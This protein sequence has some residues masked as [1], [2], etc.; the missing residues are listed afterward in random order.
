M[1]YFRYFHVFVMC[2]SCFHVFVGDVLFLC[3][4]ACLICFFVSF[5]GCFFF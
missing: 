4:H 5:V 1:F 3:V 2:F